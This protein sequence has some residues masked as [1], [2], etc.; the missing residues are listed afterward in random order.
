ARNL[1]L[2][3]HGSRFVVLK[4]NIADLLQHDSGRALLHC[5]SAPDHGAV[6]LRGVDDAI[7]FSFNI[8]ERVAG[9]LGIEQPGSEPALLMDQASGAVSRKVYS[10]NT[11]HRW[12]PN[13][14]VSANDFS[15]LLRRRR[16]RPRDTSIGLQ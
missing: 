7:G 10:M 13:R 8:R 15:A 12:K 3:I 2:A 16:Q 5:I 1:A 4:E 14:Y 6:E 9:Y 11:D